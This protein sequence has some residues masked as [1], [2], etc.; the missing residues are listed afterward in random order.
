MNLDLNG[1]VADFEAVV[2]GATY[3]LHT[4]SPFPAEEPKDEMEVIRPA[5]S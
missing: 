5:V 1:P 3:V 2:K 4:A